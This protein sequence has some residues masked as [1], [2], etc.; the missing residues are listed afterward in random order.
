MEVCYECARKTL[1]P[2]DRN[3]CLHCDLKL[4]ASGNC[5]NP[6]CNRTEDERGWDYIWAISTRTGPLKAAISRYKYEDKYGWARIF[7]RVLVGYLNANDDFD[8][9]G[10]IIP[11]P[12]YVGAGGRSWDH[13]ELV[14]ERAAVEGPQWPF[15]TG[16][17]TKTSSTTPFVG[18][19]F[20]GRARVAEDELRPALSVLRPELVNNQHVLV[21][22]DVFTGGLTLR[23]VAFKLRAAGAASVSGIVLARQP[24]GG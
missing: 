8:Q 4:K 24:Y 13:T 5:G 19:T 14:I 9:F 10:L 15:A 18:L 20:R 21:Y 17:L 23:E 16:V 12:T 3:R 2:L 6:L 11:S 1:A 7:G 22:D